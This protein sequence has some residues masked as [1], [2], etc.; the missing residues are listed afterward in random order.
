MG[1]QRA[2]AATAGGADPASPPSTARMLRSQLKLTP[3]PR[4]GLNRHGSS[5]SGSGS[6]EEEVGEGVEVGEEVDDL[7]G[8]PRRAAGN[9][10][11]A[12][13]GRGASCAAGAGRSGVRPTGAKAGGQP[14]QPAA[15]ARDPLAGVKEAHQQVGL[16]VPCIK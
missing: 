10:A 2:P 1:A 15:A 6:D 14:V 11:A 13:V 16:Q 7:G 9:G 12:G 8:T 3:P 5:S 4:R